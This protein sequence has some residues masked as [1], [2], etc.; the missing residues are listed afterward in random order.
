MSAEVEWCLVGFPLH[1][2]LKPG[3]IAFIRDFL[4]SEIGFMVY[5]SLTRIFYFSVT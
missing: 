4:N 3:E 5:A 1:T 2:R